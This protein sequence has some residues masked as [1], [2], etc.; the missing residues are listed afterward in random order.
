MKKIR[1]NVTDNHIL[2]IITVARFAEKKKGLDIIE[3]IAKI[4]IDNNFV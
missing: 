1:K 3:K 2:K 4:F